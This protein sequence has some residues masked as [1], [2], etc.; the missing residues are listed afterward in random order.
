MIEVLLIDDDKGLTGLLS[1]Y[2][3]GQGYN[4]HVAYDGVAGVRQF[5]TYR[6]DLV[7]L[8]VTMPERDGWEVLAR[9][10]EL[11]DTP[12]IMLTARDE[13]PSILR[14]FSLG[15]DDYVTKPFSFAQLA[16]R[17]KALLSRT[18]GA[19]TAGE[20]ELRQGDLIVDL[21][22]R[23]VWRDRVLIHLT[24]TE[25][26]LLVVLMRRAGQVVTKEEL[27]QDVW[28]EQYAE[29]VGYVRRYIWHL[30]KKLEPDPEN[31]RYIQNE[32]GFGYRFQVTAV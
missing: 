28:G 24:P 2:L 31:P 32:R 3:V 20:S 17:M 8:D 23:Q 11:S 25:F 26:K 1:D 19:T 18:G 30:R 14:G 21:T 5:F 9:I 13:E 29:E 10:R 16:A 4:V 6:P 15:V 22:T 7:L 12:I 27:V